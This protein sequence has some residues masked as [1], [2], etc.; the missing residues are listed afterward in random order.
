MS[1]FWVE[2]LNC[3]TYILK[4]KYSTRVVEAGEGEPL[5]LLH[6]TGGHAENY[7]RNIAPLSRHFRVLAIDFLWHG[8]SQTEGFDPQVIPPLVEVFVIK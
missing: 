5:L 8:R 7:V 3:N 6:G 4:G 1:S 2:L